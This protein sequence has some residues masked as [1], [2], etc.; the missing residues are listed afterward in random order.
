MEAGVARYNFQNK[1]TV[2]HHIKMPIFIILNKYVS[3]LFYHSIILKTEDSVIYGKFDDSYHASREFVT[4]QTTQIVIETGQKG[5][6]FV[7]PV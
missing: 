2:M 3:F 4:F 1:I 7:H 5:V 6:S